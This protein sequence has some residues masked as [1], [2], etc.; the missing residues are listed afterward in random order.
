MTP[1]KLCDSYIL[2]DLLPFVQEIHD[3]SFSEKPDY[4]RLNFILVK[5]LL[6]LD[7]IPTK[8]VLEVKRRKNIF[9]SE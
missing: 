4:N 1:E 9:Q 5:I 3:L 6:D 2:R 8:N 7:E